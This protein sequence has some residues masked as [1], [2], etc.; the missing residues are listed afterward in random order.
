MDVIRTGLPGVFIF[1][2]KVFGDARGWFMESRSQPKMKAAGFDFDF[3][4]DNHSY[5]AKRGTI[6]G[7]HFQNSPTSQT[8]IVRCIAGAVLD[9]AV[10][11]R[12]GSPTYKKWLAVELSA[13][14]KQQLLIPK[15]FGHGFLTL[16]D[17]VEFMYVVDEPYSPD[18]DRSIR[19]DDPDLA[20]DWGVADPVL[21]DKDAAAPLLRDSDCNYVYDMRRN[22]INVHS[23]S[24]NKLKKAKH[25]DRRP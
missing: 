21:S 5:T 1:E 13:D 2:P 6:R 8:K 25:K 15:G 10:D 3:V 7:I 24:K 4:Q 12:E 14:N 20:I 16:T 23:L 9:V 22:D 19:Y 17:N 18:L 11:L